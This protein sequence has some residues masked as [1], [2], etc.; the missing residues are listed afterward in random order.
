MEAKAKYDRHVAENPDLVPIEFLDE[1]R[2]A[3]HLCNTAEEANA[4]IDYH[5]GK[6]ERMPKG[7]FYY[8]VFDQ[9]S[10]LEKEDSWATREWKERLKWRDFLKRREVAQKLHGDWGSWNAQEKMD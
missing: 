1:Q 9:E 8:M 7:T 4:F 10:W 6:A 2:R 5:L 3:S